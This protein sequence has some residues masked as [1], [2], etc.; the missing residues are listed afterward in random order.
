MLGALL[1]VT[2]LFSIG[3]AKHVEKDT[4]EGSIKSA[5]EKQGVSFKSVTCPG[6]R[7]DHERRPGGR[8]RAGADRRGHASGRVDSFVS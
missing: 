2:A 5:L 1:A 6:D 7:E 4:I 8:R 3:C